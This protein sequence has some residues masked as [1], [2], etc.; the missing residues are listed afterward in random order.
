MAALYHDIWYEPGAPTGEN[1]QKSLD[2]MSE[3]WSN[4]ETEGRVV[5]MVEATA[6]HGKMERT[7]SPN[8]NV[9][10]FMDADIA[11]LGCPW[12]RFVVQN[13]EVDTEFLTVFDKEQVAKGRRAFLESMLAKETIY[14]SRYFGEHLEWRAREN[15]QRLLWEMN[16]A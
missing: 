6:K 12:P 11:G 8:R 2:I 9:Q 14:L 4:H 7:H 13:E 15:I 3:L 1:E 16:Q 5:E 10:L